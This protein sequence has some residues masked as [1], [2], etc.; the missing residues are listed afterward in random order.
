MKNATFE[1]VNFG[2]IPFWFVASE[3]DFSA[4]ESVIIQLK[5]GG[6]SKE[7]ICKYLGKSSR[8]GEKIYS[9]IPNNKTRNKKENRLEKRLNWVGSAENKSNEYYKKNTQYR[10]FLSLAEPIKIGHH[11]EKRH[12]GIFEKYENNMRKSIE[13]DEKA[14]LHKEKAENIERQLSQDIYIDDLDV[15]PRI[16]QKINALETKKEMIKKH[17]KEN[18]DNKI[19]SYVLT[20]LGAVLRKE[21]KRLETLKRVYLP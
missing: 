13:F 18:P 19:P 12:R 15:F 6:E 8:S 5:Y 10:D 1:K 9:I 16:H 21:K 17:N 20:N 3:D 14:E 7:T 4:G 11:S 2:G